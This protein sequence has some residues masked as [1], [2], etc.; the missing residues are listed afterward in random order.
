MT[1]TSDSPLTRRAILASA[2]AGASAAALGG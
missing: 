1:T 2:S